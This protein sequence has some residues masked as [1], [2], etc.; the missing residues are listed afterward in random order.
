VEGRSDLRCQDVVTI[1]PEDAKDH[2]DAIFVE[3]LSPEP[4][5]GWAVWVH[6]ADVAHYVPVGCAVDREAFARAT[7]IYLP[8]EVLPMLPPVLSNDLCSLQPR[9]DRLAISVRMEVSEDGVVRASSF[10]RSLIRVRRKLSYGEAFEILNGVNAANDTLGERVR[11]AADAAAALRKFRFSNG[12][13][14][15]DFPETKVQVDAAGRPVR[16][17]RLAH[18]LSHQLIEE[19][20]LAA[21]EAVA[22]KLKHSGRGA[23]YRVHESPDP[24]RLLEFREFLAAVGVDAGNLS[25]PGEVQRILSKLKGRE[26]EQALKIAFL[27]SLRLAVYHPDPLGHYGL[28]K[29]NYTHFTSPIR[30]Y[31]DLV[32][33]RCLGMLMGWIPAG[34][35]AVPNL[36]AVAEH[37]SMRERAAASAENEAIRMAQVELLEAVVGTRQEAVVL[38]EKHDELQ[39]QLVGSGF[40]GFVGLGRTERRGGR[41]LGRRSFG[42]KAQGKSAIPRRGDRI[43][44]EI[45][46][47]DRER[48]GVAMRYVALCR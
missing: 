24:D 34:L 2:D 43:L 16:V 33:H 44:V 25:L 48:L 31:P 11:C 8:G 17:E 26:D 21:N 32:V 45:A 1:D 37:C 42:S 18:D 15:L 23:L 5:R 29:T 12:A 38:D 20:M 10:H 41:S 30:R 39:V 47:V 36:Q 28:A 19:L 27:K 35:V 46:A 40:E 22:A 7:S 4:N 6:I 3:R 9:V 14:D 13:L